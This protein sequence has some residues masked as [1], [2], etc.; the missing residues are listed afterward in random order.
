MLW[1][2]IPPI[3]IPSSSLTTFIILLAY[4][5]KRSGDKLHP[6]RRP[7][8]SESPIDI[9][10]S[11]LTPI[12]VSQTGQSLCRQYRAILTFRSNS[13]VELCQML[14][15]NQES[16]RTHSSASVLIFLPESVTEYGKCSFVRHETILF[17]CYLISFATTNSW[18]GTS[19]PYVLWLIRM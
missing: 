1:N 2:F 18:P 10:T 4:R 13:Y 12:Q 6:W 3:W 9:N 8:S 7:R 5:A 15:R 17:L 11:L 19:W 16:R 14:S